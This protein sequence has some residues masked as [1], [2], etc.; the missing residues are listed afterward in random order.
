M[1]PGQVFHPTSAVKRAL[2][3]LRPRQ[4][5]L[6]I[7]VIAA[8]IA[9][10]LLDL[11]GVLILTLIG[12][13]A[14]TDVNSSQFS[15]PGPFDG[16][17]QEVVQRGVDMAGLTLIL[18]ALAGLFFVLKSLLNALVS[19]RALQFLANC[20]AGISQTL[21]SKLLNS[22]ISEVQS[23][24]TL[25]T[26][27]A[28]V[29]GATA[30]VVGIIGSLITLCSEISL[31]LLFGITLMLI[32]PLVTIV[33]I[34]FLAL[35]GLIVYRALGRWS[36]RIGL[37]SAETVIRSNVYVQDTLS[38]FREIYVSG[39]RGFYVTRI[40]HL[41]KRGAK[42]QADSV[43]ITQVPK[44]V[45]ETA[46][47]VGSVLL[48]GFLIATESRAEAVGTLVLFL[49][50]GSRVLPGIMRLQGAV[51]TIRSATGSSMETFLL[52]DRLAH[53]EP[54]P[55]DT[56]SAEEVASSLFL[57]HA[58]L[59]PVVRVSGVYFSYANETS[60][61]LTDISLDLPAGASLA[62][63]GA[64]GAGKSTLADLILGV[65]W[66]SQGN[67]TIGGLEPRKAIA[68]W[69]GGISYVPQNVYLI[70]GT[71]SQNVTLGMPDGSFSEEQVWEAL[72]RAHLRDFLVHQRN[73]LETH[74]GERGLHL[75]GGQRQRL[76]LARALL[77]RPRLL[78][79]DEA[80]SAL[81]AQ[82]ESLIS[83]MISE[84]HGSTTLIVIAHR[85]ATVRDFDN[86]AYLDRGRLAAIGSFDTVRLQ[87]PDFDTQARLLGL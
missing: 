82:T 1:T 3:L 45:F 86:I 81:D 66:P 57:G 42:A 29:Q 59:N 55:A 2:R 70:D 24:S 34:F 52:S 39:R 78:V 85:L 5:A 7:G 4:R 41:L 72:E 51:V 74:V 27:Y 14:V 26:A 64:T 31:L 30:A 47:I 32:D 79:L 76:G 35:I 19:R 38:S 12:V 61:S 50:S 21:I 25:T 69:P 62:L 9:M 60:F 73:G 54:I 53:T 8:Q 36:E 23:R 77:T 43:F 58:D 11:L 75:S 84:L 17:I 63:V 68:R 71:V 80:T 6:L 67:I 48:A 56:R 33:A 40:M 49:G 13:L 37:L 28:S 15:L 83:E 18:A 10:S 46:L 16:V 87:V 20:Q 22:S 44:Y 65:Q